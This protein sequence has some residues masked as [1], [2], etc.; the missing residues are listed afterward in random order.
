MH[1]A[2]GARLR[3]PFEKRNLIGVGEKRTLLD[4]LDED[5]CLRADRLYF[6]HRAFEAVYQDFIAVADIAFKNLNF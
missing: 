5:I 1:S 4:I 6:H 2:W 3:A